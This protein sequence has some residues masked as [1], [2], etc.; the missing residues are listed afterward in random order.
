MNRLPN[1][2]F[3]ASVAATLAAC[4]QP[5]DVAREH[6]D[7]SVHFSASGEELLEK[8]SP[9][10]G[11]LLSPVLPAGADFDRV[12]VLFDAKA[13]VALDVRT[14]VDDAETFGPWQP[15][16]LIFSEEEA[17]TGRADLSTG[18]HLQLRLNA[19]VE[20]GLSFVS[21]SAF[22]LEGDEDASL[23]AGATTAGLLRDNE[24]VVSVS[25]W[26][27]Q[28][29]RCGLASHT[30]NRITIHHTETPNNTSVSPATRIRQ[31]QNFHFSRGWCDVG[32]HLLI[33]HD[34]RIY[35]GRPENKRGAH[36]GSGNN[37]G[38][39]GISFVGSFMN[40]LPNDAMLDAGARA[41]RGVA[42]EWNI[43]INRSRVLGH[44]QMRSTDCPGDALYGYLDDL[45]ARAANG[46]VGPT[47]PPPSSEP[48]AEPDVIDSFPAVRNGDTSDSTRDSFDRYSCAP[49]TNEAGP[50]DIYEIHVDAE[51]WLNIQVDDGGNVDVDLHLLDALD[52]DACLD[53]DDAS[54]RYRVSP[55]TYFLAVDSYVSSSYGQRDG[56]YVL[57]VDF[58]PLPASGDACAM[59]EQQLQMF[60][61]SCAVP[62]C[63]R[64]SGKSY[65][66]LPTTGPVVKE[67]HLVTENEPFP[68]GWPGSF[69][70]GIQRHYQL[71]QD[72]TGYDM[73]RTEPWA[74]AGEGGSRYGQGSTGGVLPVEDEA[75]Y[76]TMYWRQ[77]PAKGTR[78]IVTNPDNGRAVVA[79]AGWETGPGS[80]TAVAGVSEE[81]HHYLGTGHLDD[82]T[83]GFAADDSL[84]LGPIDCGVPPAQPTP[85]D[86]TPDD[87]V[88][89]PPT[90]EPPATTQG[91]YTDL[92]PD[93]E[94]FAAAE[95]LRERGALWGCAPD[96]FC[97]GS[98]LVRDQMANLVATLEEQSVSLPSSPLFD[99]VASTHWAYEAVQELGARQITV[100]CGNGDYC[101]DLY[102]SRATFAVYL[103]RAFGL[104][105]QTPSSFDDVSSSHWAGSSIEAAY[106]AGLIEPCE[107]DSYCPDQP[108]TRGDAARYAAMAYDIE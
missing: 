12:L 51:G 89:P 98:D 86:P 101:P 79:S 96:V 17:H 108:I 95:A 90:A 8:L 64:Q 33:G 106:Q 57:R 82:L 50:E 105:A 63:S 107:G 38:N 42:E 36:A 60:W 69:T 88:T 102:V 83:I 68:S 43:D 74:P 72:A 3:A 39:V 66:S 6:E 91:S 40:T 26:G 54:I 55:G 24:D 5:L 15:L 87:P 62:D 2:L 45:V 52:D 14:S 32:Y 23:A 13:P 31:I 28:S 9:E 10:N 84:P 100:G 81:I 75:W 49:G 97:P 30:P 103:R 41:I 27:G 73:S 104:S 21:L 85:D 19:P 92:S 77:R 46:G 1:L 80:N 18:T 93:H 7:D 20:A 53:R 76:I 67:A 4:E 16:D 94:A 34:G 44:R 35:Q 48:P 58:E 70:D 37:T 56:P 22:A 65:L 29:A 47:A 25:A 59:I 61:S 11:Y 78:M 99:D 71:S